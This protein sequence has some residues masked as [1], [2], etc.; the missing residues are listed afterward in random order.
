M[1]VFTRVGGKLQVWQAK[2]M[3]YDEAIKAVRDELGVKH[4]PPILVL[5]KY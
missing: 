2:G 3:E 4:K 1:R 5:V